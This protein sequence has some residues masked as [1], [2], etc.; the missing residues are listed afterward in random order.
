MLAT[1]IHRIA[2]LGPDVQLTELVDDLDP[3]VSRALARGAVALAEEARRFS[4]TLPPDLGWLAERAI[5]AVATGREHA[6]LADGLAFLVGLVGQALVGAQ[7]AADASRLTIED[8][9]DD[10][11]PDLVD[12]RRD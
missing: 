7:Y 1:I 10:P 2:T 9:R 3:G 12:D 11:E 4:V 6:W 5:T 8:R